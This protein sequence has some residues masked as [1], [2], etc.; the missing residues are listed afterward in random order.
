MMK[1]TT[2]ALFDGLNAN[3]TIPK[4]V[5]KDLIEARDK[6]G[7]YMLMSASNSALTVR[8]KL[9]TDAYN[10]LTCHTYLYLPENEH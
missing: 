9:I 6:L 4:D 1:S 2:I 7:E 10:I 3:Q 5:L 8:E